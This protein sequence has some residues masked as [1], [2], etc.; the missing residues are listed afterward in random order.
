MQL[1]SCMRMG[2]AGNKVVMYWLGTQVS[3]M[4]ASAWLCE[5]VQGL[6]IEGAVRDAF[7]IAFFN[8]SLNDSLGLHQPQDF[9]NLLAPA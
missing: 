8:R 3:K 5:E 1:H 2:S 4:M 6:A 9:H 7:H